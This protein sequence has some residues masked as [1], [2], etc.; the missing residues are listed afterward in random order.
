L[1]TITLPLFRSVA[2]IVW[3]VGLPLSVRQVLVTILLP[4]DVIAVLC[5]SFMPTS[6]GDWPVSWQSGSSLLS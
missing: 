6:A 1:V 5:S 4:S 2:V 3:E